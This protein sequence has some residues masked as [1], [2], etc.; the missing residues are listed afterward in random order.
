MEFARVCKQLSC[1]TFT[2]SIVY[3]HVGLSRFARPFPSSSDP[4]HLEENEGDQHA[5]ITSA[6]QFLSDN[7][8]S[9]WRG[10]RLA[11]ESGFEKTG[12]TQAKAKLVQHPRFAEAAACLEHKI[13]RR[14]ERGTGRE[15]VIGEILLVHARDGIIDPVSKRVSEEHYKPVGR[16]IANRF[17]TTRQRFNLRGDLP[18]STDRPS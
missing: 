18:P 10:I 7:E 3:S 13:E 6:G 12:L 8:G 16:L 15:M 17:C 11:E 9:I 4:R 1:G 14:L 2:A 5:G